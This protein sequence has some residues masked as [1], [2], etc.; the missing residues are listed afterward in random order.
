[1]VATRHPLGEQ[2]PV[3]RWGLGAW[4]VF[5][6]FGDDLLEVGEAGAEC[7][8]LVD[9]FAEGVAGLALQDGHGRAVVGPELVG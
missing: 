6:V 8:L 4:G 2:V 7:Q 5:P 9:L 1:M 3:A